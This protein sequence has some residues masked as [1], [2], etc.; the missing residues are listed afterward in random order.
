MMVKSRPT[1]FPCG[2]MVRHS[3]SAS[4]CREAF[5]GSWTR[6]KKISDST[7]VRE[8]A[9][10]TAVKDSDRDQILELKNEAASIV[11]MAMAEMTA[12][13]V[14]RRFSGHISMLNVLVPT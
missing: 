2:R 9:T 5:L 14:A 8:D 3:D 13:Y 4:Y 1:F 11:G 10:A 7:T 6:A 12:R